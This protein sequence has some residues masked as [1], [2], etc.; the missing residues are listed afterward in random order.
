MANLRQYA[1]DWQPQSG[2]AALFGAGGAARAVVAALFEVGVPEI[3]IANRTRLRAE[4]LRADFGARLTVCDWTQ[5]G[6]ML[7]GAASWSTPRRSACPASRISSSASR[8]SNAT[9]WSPISS[10]RP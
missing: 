8:L 9:P 6:Q 3:R 1:P 5:A 7:E 10:S 4:T 2:P